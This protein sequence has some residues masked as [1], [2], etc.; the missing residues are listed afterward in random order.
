[1]ADPVNP[2]YLDKR[3]TERYQRS[4]H[5]SEEDYKRHIAGLEDVSEKSVPVETLMQ[6]EDFEDDEDEDFEDEGDE[7][8]GDED[9][10]TGSAE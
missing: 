9:E 5:V 6:D 4:G 3:T 1:M 10:D 2:K 7:D 8:E